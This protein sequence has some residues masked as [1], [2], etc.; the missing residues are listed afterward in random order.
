MLELESRGIFFLLRVC[1]LSLH[2]LGRRTLGE[3][4]KLFAVNRF[5]GLRC[6]FGGLWRLSFLWRWLW[7]GV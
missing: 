4:G 7:I 2:V 3:F 6:G 5:A 1:F